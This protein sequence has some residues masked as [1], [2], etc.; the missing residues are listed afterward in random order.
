[1]QK[2]D[3]QKKAMKRGERKVGQSLNKGW[4]ESGMDKQNTNKQIAKISNEKQST[5]LEAISSHD[6]TK[7]RLAVEKFRR[8]VHID[9]W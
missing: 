3:E 8:P 5:C 1:M 6:G 2:R 4:K 7:D 9:G